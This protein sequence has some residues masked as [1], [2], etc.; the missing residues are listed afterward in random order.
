MKKLRF[1][2]F[3]KIIFWVFLN[4]LFVG[5]ILMFIFNLDFRFSPRSPF[6]RESANRIEAVSRLISVEMNGASEAERDEVLAKYSEAY[7]VEFFAFDENAVQIA[8]VKKEIPEQVGGE[9]KKYISTLPQMEAPPEVLRQM[10]VNKDRSFP[11]MM[12]PPPGRQPFFVRTTNPT[13]YWSGSVM[14]LFNQKQNPPQRLLLLTASNSIS[15]HG[16]F[17]DPTPWLIIIGVVT[18]FSIL[19]WLP[20]VRSLTNA[21]AQVT[22]ATEKIADE[23]F[24]VRVS[25]KRTDEIGR[26]GIAINQLATR[27]SGFVHGQKRF[28]GDISHE[29][30]SPLARLQLALTIIED[31]ADEKTRPYL[32]KAQD[33][34]KLMSKLIGELLTYSKAG[35]QTQQVKLETVNVR[36]T[37]DR[38]IAREKHK[39]EVEIEVDVPENLAVYANSEMLVRAVANIVRNAIRYAGSA[40]VINIEASEEDS[41]VRL[42]IADSGAGVPDAE[43]EKMFDPFYRL[44]THRSRETGGSGLGLAIVKTCVEACRGKVFARN[45]QP[46]GLEIRI[47]LQKAVEN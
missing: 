7:N 11:R 1:P 20:L 6:F 10:G 3:A 46:S 16:L 41:H 31:E 27:L 40:G 29:L 15:G 13:L 21:V 45:R 39:A 26:L 25:E 35:L 18:V 28:L 43:L 36:E 19:F 12:P 8:G 22:E 32:L 23:D 42:L 5:G 17:F 2:L 33:E 4:L 9:L 37:V 47:V 14:M 24:A 30:N 34:V 44:E 38:V